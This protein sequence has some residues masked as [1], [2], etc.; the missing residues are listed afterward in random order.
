MDSLSWEQRK[1]RIEECML[2]SWQNRWDDGSEPGR[3]THRLV[4]DVTLIYRPY[5][6]WMHVLCACPLY[7]D[8]LDLDGLGVQR[9]GETWTFDGIL[10]D[11]ERT[12]R[13]IEF[14]EQAFRRRRGN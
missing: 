8:L 13:L 12:Q 1:M 11:R 14:A 3:V 4:P 6:D 2:L 9:V 5:E 10:E 7:E